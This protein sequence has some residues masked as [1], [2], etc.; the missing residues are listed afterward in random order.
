MIA[1]IDIGTES[2]RLMFK[3]N[4]EWK[5]LKKSYRIFFPSPEA[6][7]QDP[8]EILSAVYYLLKQIPK[9]GDVLYVGMSSVFHSVVGLDEDF[10][11]VTP[12]LNWVDRRSYREKEE[13]EKKYGTRFFYERTACP[14]HPM[15]WPSKILWMKKNSDSKKFCSIKA[16][17]V[18]KLTGE[19]VEEISLASGT[20]MMNIHSLEWDDEILG[21]VGVKKENLPE[22]KSPY[23]QLKAKEEV[24]KELGFREVYLVLGGGD[25]VMT[26]VGLNAMDP[27]S[28]TVTIGTSGAFRVVLDRPVIDREGISTWCYLIDEKNYVLGGAINNGGIVL[29]WLKDV[30]KFDSYDEIIEEA[31]KSSIGANGLVFLPFLNGERAPHWRERYR[32]VLVGLASSHRRSDI[33]RA[34]LEGI[35]FRIKDIYNAVKK[36]GN[37]DPVR[38]VA[39]GGFTSSPYWVQLLADVLG[40]D[41]TVTNVENPSA[42]GAYVMALKSLGESVEEFLEKE[43]HVEQVFRC[44]PERNEKYEQLYD[45]YRF[46]YEKLVDYF[47]RE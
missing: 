24:A 13:L 2:A 31:K 15:Y 39:T 32:G 44:D 37:V 5:V 40:K 22:L 30:M 11:P 20:G 47:Y 29:M 45:D 10:N 34:A 35:C 36:V 16:F 12:L 25:G 42:F 43:V 41:I 6:V 33:A 26:N 7:E 1:A 9:E 4:G 28:A 3:S 38:I 27:D 19:F 18:N 17:I 23:A 21:I 14:L 46:L 8:K